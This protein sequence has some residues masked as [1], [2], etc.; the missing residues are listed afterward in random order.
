M[1]DHHT[2]NIVEF[3]AGYC[4]IGLGLHAVIPN[5]RTIAYVERE[6]WAVAN[7]VAKIE[8][9]RMDAAPI[10]TDL[11]TFPYRSFY[12]LVDIAAAG[13][14]CQPHSA[15]GKRQGGADERFLFDIFFDGLA[16]MQPGCILIKNVEGLL[17]SK[18][19]DGTLCIG[20]VLRR[21]EEIGYRVENSAGK[22]S[23]GVFSAAE[24]G[25]PHQ[26]KRVF[27]VAHNLGERGKELIG[28]ITMES[29]QHPPGYGSIWPARPGQ[30][31]YEWEEPRVV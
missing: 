5:L 8:E 13:I 29:Q 4:G 22:L 15:A 24:V 7:L 3:C 6:A 19:P 23:L 25:A 30:P 20:Y 17:S 1:H 27:I 10:Y 9:G 26:R 12:G 18:M 31:Q 21:L 16:E 11:T 14:P 28:K 2:T